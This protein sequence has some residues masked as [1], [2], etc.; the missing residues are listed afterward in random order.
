MSAVK[1]NEVIIKDLPL[2]L[3][4]FNQSL[5]GT[6]YEGVLP[7]PTSSNIKEYGETLFNYPVIMNRF[8]NQLVNVV[9][10]VKVR[11]MYYTNDFN[12]AKRGKIPDGYTL[13]QI[14]VDVCVAHSYYEKPDDLTSFAAVE[15]PNLR[16]IYHPR[17]REDFFKQT[18]YTKDLRA[19]FYSENGMNALVIR[20]I[21]GMYTSNDVTEFTYALACIADYLDSNM[22]KL[23]KVNPVTDKDSAEDFLVS[24][25]E[26]SIAFRFPERKYN[27]MGVMNTSSA[28]NQRVWLTPKAAANVDV[29][30][31]ASAFNMDR[32]DFIGRVTYI[33]E[34]PNHPEIIGLLTDDEFLNIYDNMF[35]ADTWWN[36]EK[37]YMNYWLHVWQTY[38]CSPFHNGIAFT[39]SE[40]PTVT[41]VTVSA[42]PT[43]YTPGGSVVCKAVVD[44]TNS[45]SNNGLWTV[46]GKTS[47]STRIDSFGVLTTGTEESGDLT[48][49]FKPFADN[50]KSGQL[51]IKKA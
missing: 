51:V 44:G 5:K 47:S 12:F 32:A 37:L 36:P 14:W 39:T 20:I 29:K 34:I 4:A 38:F 10:F 42:T 30:A 45:P 13:E 6:E 16:V 19:A 31:L 3:R 27:P 40:I 7:E 41:N 43:A 8:F 17:N 18:I 15:T 48:V 21:N 25:R 24:A 11:N 1:T 26:T 28:S 49:T 9:A 50:T 23:V 33:P 35:L 22:I 2:M 46:E